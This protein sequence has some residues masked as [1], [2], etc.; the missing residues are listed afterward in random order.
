[1]AGAGVI[2][3]QRFSQQLTVA[4]EVVE[5]AVVTSFVGGEVVHQVPR[6]KLLSGIEPQRSQHLRQAVDGLPLESHR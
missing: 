4:E 5:L 1:M 6:A 3:R 2:G